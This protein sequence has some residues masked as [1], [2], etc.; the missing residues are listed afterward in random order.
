EQVLAREMIVPVEHPQFGTIREVRTAIR[1]A[2]GK[3]HRRPMPAL[4]ADTASVL[5][6]LLGYDE[7]EVIRLQE[8]GAI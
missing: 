3:Q 8:A 5:Q 6:E 7:S 4:G 1:V 2:G